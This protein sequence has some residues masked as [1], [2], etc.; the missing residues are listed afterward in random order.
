MALTFFPSLFPAVSRLSTTCC[1]FSSSQ[2]LYEIRKMARMRIVDNSAIGKAASNVGKP[3]RVIHVYNKRE[4][5]LLGDKVLVTVKGEMKRAY[6]VGL[7]K[8]QAPNVPRMD[9]N[10]I[11]LVDDNGNPL[12][13]RIMVPIPSSLRGKKGD[14]TKILSLATRFV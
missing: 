13:N 7:R 11:V 1:F 10:N 12:G 2:K 3:A 8:N 4:V 6:I 5:G 9:T 14:L